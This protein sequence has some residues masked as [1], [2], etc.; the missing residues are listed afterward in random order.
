MIITLYKK[1]RN[2]VLWITFY[3]HLPEP[4]RSQRELRSLFHL[5]PVNGTRWVK[6]R[7][8]PLRLPQKDTIKS[9]PFCFLWCLLDK[10]RTYYEQNPDVG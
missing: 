2:F 10:V 6:K 7:I 5:R 4:Q 1:T 9:C 8:Y 3:Q